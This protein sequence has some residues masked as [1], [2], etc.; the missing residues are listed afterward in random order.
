MTTA[1]QIARWNA[2]G[3]PHIP[4]HIADALVMYIDHGAKP[5]SFTTACIDN[6]ALGASHHAG[7]GITLDTIKGVTGFL[8]NYAPQNCWGSREKRLV[9]QQQARSRMAEAV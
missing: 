2:N 1:E 8:Y 6:D 7:A 4:D 3:S 9:W 5:G